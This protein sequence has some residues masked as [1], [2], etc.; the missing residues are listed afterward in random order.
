MNIDEKVNKENV[1]LFKR[2]GISHTEDNIYTCV[3]CGKKTCINC[4]TSIHGAYVVCNKCVVNYFSGN[5][6]NCMKW[7]DEMLKKEIENDK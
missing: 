3:F 5:W 4:S 2:Y 7:Q 6:H 1:K